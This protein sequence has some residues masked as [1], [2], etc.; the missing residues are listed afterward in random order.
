VVFNENNQP[1][2][3]T[4]VRPHLLSWGRDHKDYDGVQRKLTDQ[5]WEL[6]KAQVT[7]KIAPNAEHMATRFEKKNPTTAFLVEERMLMAPER[8]KERRSMAR[9]FSIPATVAEVLP[10]NQYKLRWHMDCRL[11]K[12]CEVGK[13]M[14]ASVYLKKVLT[15]TT[16]NWGDVDIGPHDVVGSISDD[17]EHREFAAHTPGLQ[18]PV[19]LNAASG[20]AYAPAL[21]VLVS[22]QRL[23][24]NGECAC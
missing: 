11:G 18:T 12:A 9:P 21:T 24:N 19:G 7:T 23:W 5:E 8:I 13:Q 16:Q 14:Y 3:T 1:A 10:G 6:M 2:K 17:R 15:N 22:F 4:G 20:T